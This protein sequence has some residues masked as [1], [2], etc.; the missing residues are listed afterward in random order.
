M[1]V[2]QHE[3]EYEISGEHRQVRSCLL[4]KGE[5]SLQTAMAKTVGLPLCI[6]ARLILQ[7]K[8][9]ATGLQIPTIPEIYSP[10]LKELEEEGIVFRE[11]N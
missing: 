1:V 10:V 9:T 7:G 6:A 4:V 8:I 3:I 2:M 11:S 5:N